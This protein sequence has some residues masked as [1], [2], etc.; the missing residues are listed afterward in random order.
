M[1]TS[2]TQSMREEAGCCENKEGNNRERTEKE[3][4]WQTRYKAKHDRKQECAK[5][6]EDNEETQEIKVQVRKR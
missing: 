6:Y 2:R 1:V 4:Q 5:S 3:I